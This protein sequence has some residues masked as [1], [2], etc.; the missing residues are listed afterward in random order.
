MIANTDPAHEKRKALEQKTEDEQKEEL[1]AELRQESV[2]VIGLA[3][4]FARGFNQ[5]GEDLIRGWTI[6]QQARI[7]QS[8]YNAGYRAGYIDGVAKGKEYEREERAAQE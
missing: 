6:E 2:S 1:I 7:I 8:Q 5:T 3:V 4:M